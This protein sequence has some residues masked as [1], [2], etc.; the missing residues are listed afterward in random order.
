MK[1]TTSLVLRYQLTIAGIALFGAVVQWVKAGFS[2][3]L[4][5]FAGLFLLLNLP[6]AY[7]WAKN[8]LFASRRR[9]DTNPSEAQ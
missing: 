8:A 6:L 3:A 4:V 1:L 5:V 9:S 2:S 7:Q